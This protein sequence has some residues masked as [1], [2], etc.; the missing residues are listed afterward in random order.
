MDLLFK[1]YASPFSLLDEVIKVSQFEDWVVFFLK[2]QDAEKNEHTMWEFYLHKVYDKNFQ[3]WK[4]EVTNTTT[5]SSGTV[6]AMD[7]AKKEEII[8]NSK[9]IL[10]G[11][12]P[13]VM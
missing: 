11:F 4:K 13:S 5:D 9:S 8:Q 3:E 6:V 7:E 2:K 1:K 12:N 10:D